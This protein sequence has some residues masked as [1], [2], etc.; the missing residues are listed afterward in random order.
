MGEIP[1]FAVEVYHPNRGKTVVAV[2]GEL[3]L[4]NA[5]KLRGP[6]IKAVSSISHECVVLDLSDCGFLDSSGLRLLLSAQRRA[7]A[8]GS[9]LRIAG[10]GPAVV[11]VIELTAVD[12]FL[13]LFPDVPAALGAA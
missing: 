5:E 13:R 9:S 7:Q 10:S 3:D 4:G 1:A 11:R 2:S 8:T 6:L 12:K